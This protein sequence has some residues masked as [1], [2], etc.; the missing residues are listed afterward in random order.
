MKVQK[1]SW[2]PLV[3]GIAFGLLAI[4]ASTANFIIPIGDETFIGIGEAFATLSAALG[5]PI[6]MVSMLVVAYGGDIILNIDLC[7]SPQTFYLVLADFTTHLYA[8]PGVAIGYSKFLSTRARK[9]GIFLV[10]WWLS[11][12]V[13]CLVLLAQSV[14]LLF[15][16]SPGFR[17]TFPHFTDFIPEFLG[18]AVKPTI[19]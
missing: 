10:G 9:T 16:A 14:I 15:V 3:I 17:A 5:G 4:F 19:T 8:K 2:I 12:I 6:A 7:T 18:T 1:T 13:Y 11:V